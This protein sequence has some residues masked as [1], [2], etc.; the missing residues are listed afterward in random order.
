MRCSID[1]LTLKFI[2]GTKIIDAYQTPNRRRTLPFNGHQSFQGNR[3]I[4]GA[5]Q[6]CT[7][8]YQLVKIEGLDFSKVH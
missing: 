7:N 2:S 3:A 6:G 4:F 1:Q 5:N 8:S